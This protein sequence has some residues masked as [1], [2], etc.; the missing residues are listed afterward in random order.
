MADFLQDSK[1]SYA[2]VPGVR[3]QKVNMKKITVFSDSRKCFIDLLH[4]DSDPVCW[5]VRRWRKYIGFKKWLSSDW[6]N[7]REQAVAFAD[8]LV[9]QYNLQNKS[10]RT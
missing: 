1:G 3:S 7:E 9:R 8:G 2:E 10:V 4:D 6:F 5:I